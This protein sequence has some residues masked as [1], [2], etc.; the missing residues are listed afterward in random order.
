MVWSAPS[1]H[2]PVL[3]PQEGGTHVDVLYVSLLYMY[4]STTTGRLKRL[5]M[6]APLLPAE[7]GL[8]QKVVPGSWRQHHTELR[9]IQIQKTKVSGWKRAR[10]KRLFVFSEITFEFHNSPTFTQICD[11]M[12]CIWSFV[13]WMHLSRQEAMGSNPANC[14]T[15]FLFCTKNIS[16]V[17]IVT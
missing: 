11:I 1:D 9:V 6:H 13:F 15:H 14:T 2:K 17:V 7:P 12:S 8:H 10:T 5:T 4:L 16:N 3:A